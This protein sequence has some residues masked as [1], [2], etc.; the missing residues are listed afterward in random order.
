M[1]NLHKLSGKPECTKAIRNILDE[2]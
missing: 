2:L 1:T